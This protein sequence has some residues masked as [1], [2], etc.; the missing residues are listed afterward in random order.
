MGPQSQS[1]RGGEEKISQPLPAPEPPIIQ[2]VAQPYTTELSRL[3]LYNMPL[4]WSRKMRK[5]CNDDVN[6]LGEKITT[7]KKNTETLLE[8]K[9]IVVSRH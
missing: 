4:G 6:I 2:P 5:V 9:Y 1:G 7:I 8:A 3:L